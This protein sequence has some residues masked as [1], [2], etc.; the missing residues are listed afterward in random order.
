M[1][2]CPCPHPQRLKAGI[3]KPEEAIVAKQLLGKQLPAAKNTHATIE[4]L[5]D[6]VFSIVS[7]ISM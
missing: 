7:V 5:L 4:E 3:L 2:V 1:P 6:A